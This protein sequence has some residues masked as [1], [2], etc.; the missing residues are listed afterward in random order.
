[1]PQLIP[2]YFINEVSF[3]FIILII[4]IYMLSKYILPRFILLYLIRIYIYL[5]NKKK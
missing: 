1:M 3:A 5:L 4:I 2:F